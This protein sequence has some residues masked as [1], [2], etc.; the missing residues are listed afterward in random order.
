MVIVFD[1]AGLTEG[2]TRDDVIWT[3]TA[4]LFESVADVKDGL[5]VPTFMPLTLHW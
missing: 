1:V 5:L 4:S 2:H 3:V